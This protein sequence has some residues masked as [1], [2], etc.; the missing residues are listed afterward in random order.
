[1]SLTVIEIKALKP[2]TKP[3]KIS[4]GGGLYLFVSPAG[5]KV[6]RMNYTR[7]GKQR[8][9]TI[10]GFDRVG[11]QAARSERDRLKDLIA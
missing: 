9:H 3:Y 2:K 4:D 1:M 8:T 10:G 7:G 6:W 11:L 5:A